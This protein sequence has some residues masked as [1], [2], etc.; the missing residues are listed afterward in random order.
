MVA[1]EVLK[2]TVAQNICTVAMASI[3]TAQ[4]KVQPQ[5]TKEDLEK[6]FQELIRQYRTAERI[7]S[8]YPEDTRQ[9]LQLYTKELLAFVARNPGFQS[10]A[11]L[12][13]KKT[14]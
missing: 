1:L 9:L 14:V 2:F 11:S 6:E 7:S 13:V 8:V 4:I 3:Q 5:E 12:I 10:R